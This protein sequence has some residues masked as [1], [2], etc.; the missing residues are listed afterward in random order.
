MNQIGK[1]K[2]VRKRRD[3]LKTLKHRAEE[4][5]T[6]WGQQIE[7][8]GGYAALVHWYS[9]RIASHGPLAVPPLP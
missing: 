2:A 8:A 1:G 4:T 7:A 5:K 3:F 6:D 9:E